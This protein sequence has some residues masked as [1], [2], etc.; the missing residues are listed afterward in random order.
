MSLYP[1]ST[2]YTQLA[3]PAAQGYGAP[4]PPPNPYYAPPPVPQPYH[5]DPNVFR[6][7]YITRLSNLTVNSRPIIQSLSMIAQ[8][9]SR[10]ADV[11]VQCIEQHLRRVPP[12]MKLPSFYLLDAIAKNVYDPYARHFTPVVVRL[13]VDT[14]EA[15]DPTTRSKMEEMLLTWRTGAPDGRE[16]FGVVPQLAIERHIWGSNSTQ[17]TGNRGGSQSI[18]QAQVL[19]ELEFVL[20]QKE[21]VLQSNPYDKATQSHV[22][23]LQQLRTLVQTGVSQGELGQIL[24]Q[25][26]TLTTPPASSSPPPAPTPQSYPAPQSY[27]APPGPPG[28][29]AAPPAYP[30]QQ[31]YPTSFEQPKAEPMDLSRLLAS[32]GASMPSTS[33]APAV[34]DI[35]N[36]FSALVKA[37]VVPATTGANVAKVEE[38][39][40]PADPAREAARAY[41]QLIRSHK[42]KLTSSD[43]TRSRVP[44]TEMLYDRLPTQCKQCSARFSDS[45]AG[46]KQF[47]DH[48]DMHFRQNRKASQAVGR[49]H[50]RSWFI[51]MEDWVHGE[52]VDVKG[53]GRADGRIV[54]TKA[55]AAEEAAKRDAELRAMFVVV[56]PGDEAKPISCPICK[57]PLKSEFLEDDEEWV[58]RNAIKKDDRIY[59]ATCHAEAI[60]SKSSLASR[61]RNEA[62]SRSRSRTPETR[63]PPKALATL[64]GDSGKSETPTPSRLAGMKRKAEDDSVGLGLIKGEEDAPQAKRIAT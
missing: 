40:A 37:G 21:R 20:G 27:S 64:N 26:R 42:V 18:S 46:K 5:V 33:T 56:P 54:N 34:P 13:F 41:R 15:V 35:A 24:S 43:I 9:Y 49:G 29:A 62:S 50:S 7:D 59:H 25:L 51:T 60:A 17:S 8:D 57:E 16:L 47:E 28:P 3:Y 48:L 11:V 22:A 23:I 12:W 2:A 32:A 38:T 19:S 63:T 36:L 4:L 45:P 14:Y 58:W 52:V 61:L 55:A 30:P 6:R 10:F 44:I 53:K 31:S 39:S 1:Q